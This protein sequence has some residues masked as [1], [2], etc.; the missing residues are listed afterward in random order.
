MYRYSYSRGAGF[1]STPP[2]VLWLILVNVA[3]FLVHYLLAPAFLQP[4]GYPPALTVSIVVELFGFTPALALGRFWLWQFVTYMFLHGGFLHILVNMLMLWMFGSDLER[5]WGLRPFLRY[6]F[7][8]GIGAAL[9]MV[10]FWRTP[11]VGASGA[12]FGVLVAFAMIY[13]NRVL[14]LWA[15]FP[16]KAKHLIIGAFLVE[17]FLGMTTSH[18]GFAH[19]AHVGGAVV[20]YLYLK[21]AW[22]VRHFL[23]EVSWHRRRGRFTVIGDEERRDEDPWVH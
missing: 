22:R 13:P 9:F 1:R 8:T 20:G 14:Y 2:G 12:I 7:I 15:V 5:L 3:A 18:S 16:V 4:V 21:R 23:S 11:T 6:Y 10:P 17:L 19:L